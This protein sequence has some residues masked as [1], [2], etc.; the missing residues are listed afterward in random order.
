MNHTKKMIAPIIITAL[1]V[2][3]YVGMVVLFLCVGDI[4]FWA[5]TVLVIAPLAVCGVMIGVLVSRIKEIRGGE[6]DDLSKY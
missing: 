5:K 4:P 1:M 2:L 6:E 3:Y